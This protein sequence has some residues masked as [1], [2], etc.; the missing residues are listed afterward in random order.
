MAGLCSAILFSGFRARRQSDVV[1][2]MGHAIDMAADCSLS[3]LRAREP[4]N[5]R[6]PPFGAPFGQ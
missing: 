4:S 2:E 5:W 6:W 1:G 3:T